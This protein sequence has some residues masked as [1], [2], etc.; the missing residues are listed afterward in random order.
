MTRDELSHLRQE[1]YSL[2]YNAKNRSEDKKTYAQILELIDYTLELKSAVKSIRNL[3]E[4]L[5]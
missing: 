1:V 2:W 5:V 4:G 3:Y